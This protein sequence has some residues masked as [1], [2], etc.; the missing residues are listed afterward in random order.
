ML[1]NIVC[2][3]LFHSI[4]KL[5]RK[6]CASIV[7]RTHMGKHRKKKKNRKYDGGQPPPSTL[8]PSPTP[9]H[10]NPAVH[11]T[12]WFWHIVTLF[13]SLGFA[14]VV[15]NTDSEVVLY[16]GW[17]VWGLTLGLFL[18][19][20]FLKLVWSLW[21]KVAF[22]LAAICIFLWAAH[23]NI[24][25]RL[26]PS[27]VSVVPGVL[28]NGDSWDII[29]NHRGPKTSY[30]TQILFVDHDRQD[31]V[32][33][34][35]STLSLADINSY[36]VL[37]TLPEVNPMGRGT[38]FAQQMVW[39]PYNLAHS[40]FIA[41]ISWRDGSVHEELEIAKVQD[42]W[43]YAMKVTNREG[44]KTLVPCHDKLFPS[45]APL[46]PCFPVWTQPGS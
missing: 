1:G 40:H 37:W 28:F 34:P 41:D 30:S 22:V 39:K 12:E 16:F 5:Q 6:F 20:L 19:A 11:R 25:E 45:N 7:L 44:G 4:A 10:A 26:R 15:N 8:P 33:H 29:A 43:Q 38:I 32:A 36:Q 17:C 24:Q 31:Y 27:F 13:I 35:Q 23:S 18:H 2:H 9:N 46:S 14:I 21:T 3:S 42:T